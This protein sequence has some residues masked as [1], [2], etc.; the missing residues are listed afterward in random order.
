MITRTPLGY[1]TSRFWRWKKVNKDTHPSMTF[2]D[3]FT[4]VFKQLNQI[5]SFKLKIIKIEL[6][7]YF[8]WTTL[9][10]NGRKYRMIAK[11]LWMQVNLL[12]M[13]YINEIPI[14]HNSTKK[15]F[16][17]FLPWRYSL[18]WSTTHPLDFRH[19]KSRKMSRPNHLLC[20]A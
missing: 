19:A 12:L 6:N 18:S 5:V 3:T 2:H 17:I 8:Q 11:M 10:S 4:H 7:L 15:G 1:V 16:M 14:F 13:F 9:Y 20:V